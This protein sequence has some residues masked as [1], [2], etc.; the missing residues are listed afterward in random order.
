MKISLHLT[1]KS[2]NH[3]EKEEKIKIESDEV[4]SDEIDIQRQ[5]RIQDILY[6][7]EQDYNDKITEIINVEKVEGLPDEYSGSYLLKESITI[8]DSERKIKRVE[9]NVPELIS[10]TKTFKKK[11]LKRVEYYTI[12]FRKCNKNKGYIKIM[13]KEETQ[14]DRM[15]GIYIG[16]LPLERVEIGSLEYTLDKNFWM[17]NLFCTKYVDELYFN[18]N[19]N[20]TDKEI[21]DFIKF[22]SQFG[23]NM[24]FVYQKFYENKGNTDKNHEEVLKKLK[25]FVFMDKYVL[26]FK[27]FIKNLSV[28]SRKYQNIKILYEPYFL[29]GFYN[30][31]DTPDKI[32]TNYRDPLTYK[33]CNLIQFVNHIHSICDIHDNLNIVLVFNAENVMKTVILC[34]YRDRGLLINKLYEESRAVSNFYSNFINEDTKYIAFD[35]YFIDGGNLKTN[36]WLWNND[37]WM[38]YLFFIKS[39]I[40]NI[41]KEHQN[42]IS[43]VLYDIPVG[44]MNNSL[45]K[46]M[47][48]NKVF[49]DHTN[50]MCDGEDSST[51][52]LFG[53]SFTPDLGKFYNNIWD[54]WRLCINDGDISV[55]EHLSLCKEFNI[56][57]VLLGAGS[58]R[59]TSHLP[60]PETGNKTTDHYFTFTKLHNFF[61]QK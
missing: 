15:Y 22:S 48:T 27:T 32:L 36:R 41:D 52:F 46:S 58:C 5:T 4:E 8:K 51:V 6:L 3:I 7:Y 40:F 10:I 60:L 30:I 42:Y 33:Q 2:E 45:E 57:T 37:E 35:K 49:E 20:T 53:G 17:D 61:N 38:N 54:D 59:S 39:V 23:V 18:V 16:D 26:K 34:K 12:M 24:T 13:Y 50:N 11:I 43:A 29:S 19:K 14:E 55:K 56:N 31:A 47:Y 28:Y 9:T 44:H 25:S 1:D 21:Q